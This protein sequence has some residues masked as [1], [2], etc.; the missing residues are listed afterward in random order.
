MTEC[1]K[2]SLYYPPPKQKLQN[3]SIAPRIICATV[4]TTSSRNLPKSLQKTE[5]LHKKI[6]SRGKLPHTFLSPNPPPP[7]RVT[8]QVVVNLTKQQKLRIGPRKTKKESAT[9]NSPLISVYS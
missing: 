3:H 9:V 8:H 7:S 4:A 5:A 2:F 6:P 1:F